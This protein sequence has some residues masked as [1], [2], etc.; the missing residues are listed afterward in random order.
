MEIYKRSLPLLASELLKDRRIYSEENDH[1]SNIYLSRLYIFRRFAYFILEREINEIDIYIKPFV[2]SLHLTEETSSFIDEIMSAE[3][4]INNKKQF[5]YVWNILYPKVVQICTSSSGL[6]LNNVLI[7]YLLA[8]RWWR[9]D[10]E[11]W[12]RLTEDNLSFFTNISK[13]LGHIPAILYSITRVL[14]TIGSKF[15]REGIDWIYSIVSKN[16]SLKMTDLESNTLYYMERF[17]R[18]FIFNNKEQI[19]R[20]IRLKNKLIPILDFMIE[21][22]SIRGYLLRESIM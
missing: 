20:E 22:G 18:K 13:D 12:H 11:E 17:I 8:W 9:E 10:I 21:R 15:K 16:S 2:N 4:N 6:Y 14:N 5:W 7:S 1:D 3:D 19:K